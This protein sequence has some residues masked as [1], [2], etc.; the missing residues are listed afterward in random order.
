MKFR[1]MLCVLLLS[2]IA[3]QADV[4]G[5][6]AGE[7]LDMVLARLDARLD[8][9]EERLAR[10][11]GQPVAAA[12]GTDIAG[13]LEAIDRQLRM[14]EPSQAEGGPPGT[15]Y[16]TPPPVRTA[17]TAAAVEAGS[18]GFAIRSTDGSF[19]MRVG[20]Y[21]QADSR[22]FLGPGQADPT[23]FVLR[24]IRPVLSGTLYD[25]IEFRLMPD[26]G[27]GTSVLQDVHL[28]FRYFTKASVRFGKFKAPFSLERLQSATDMT[29]IERAFPTNL[30]PN[31]DVGVEV[32]GD[33]E[34]GPGTLGYAVALMNGV[35]DG[36]SADT[37]GND[38]KDV[39]A[40]IFY[41]PF[42]RQTSHAANGL[43][44]GIAASQGRQDGT[45]LPT[46]RTTPQ[47]AFFTFAQG[48][49]AAG[50]RRR[51]GPQA[52]FYTGP[53]GVL[54][55]YTATEQDLRRGSAVDTIRNRGWQVA[56]SYFLTGEKKSYRSPAPNHPFDPAAGGAGAIE[57]T[58]RYTELA[59]DPSAFASGFA[60]ASRSA[61]K[62]REWTAGINWHVA[63][64]NKFIIDY[65]HT[66]FTGGSADGDRA[67]ERTLLTRFQVAF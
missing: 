27:L 67:T 46:Y 13:R 63:R 41:Q 43:G 64:G 28:D 26:F 36:A 6:A 21:F 17:P 53:F 59:V 48:T 55:E 45:V 34:T 2:S 24:R 52:H 11:E 9:I 12:P 60:E 51:I 62:A 10:L 18:S 15:A 8:A 30:A 19:Q 20:G 32:F 3:G 65:S 39:V 5:Q 35:P 58:G 1:W 47:S 42:A 16:T 38:G 56:A 44:F 23:T 7:T 25:H 49:T 57:L 61:R 54:A 22:S 14:I 40:R 31:R 37:D 33:L 4:F 66:R 50:D 29:F